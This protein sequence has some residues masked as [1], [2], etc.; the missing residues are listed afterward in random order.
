MTFAWNLGSFRK[1]RQCIDLWCEGLAYTQ[2]S[3]ARLEST[4][5]MFLYLLGCVC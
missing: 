3:L 5:M 2:K 4:G 1:H